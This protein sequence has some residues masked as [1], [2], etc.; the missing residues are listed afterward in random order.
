MA[1][2][3]TAKGYLAVATSILFF[4]SF[5]SLVKSSAVQARRVHPVV[6]Q[7]YFSVAIFVTG[8]AT[9]LWEDFEL[10][11]YGALGGLIWTCCSLLSFVSITHAGLGRAQGIWS[12]SSIVVSF[13]IGTVAFAERLKSLPWSLAALVMMLAGVAAIAAVD[14]GAWTLP[15]LMGF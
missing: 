3:D 2:D 6:I 7:L 1:L 12:G 4:G 13:F 5:G 10:T 14:A 9:V 11:A 8:F 15:M